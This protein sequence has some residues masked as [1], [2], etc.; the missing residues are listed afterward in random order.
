[1]KKFFITLIAFC[2]FVFLANADV[3]L[4]VAPTTLLAGAKSQVA[5]RVSSDKP[6][7][8]FQ[9]I[10]T[11][12][13]GLLFTETITEDSRT[14][15]GKCD[16]FACD[17]MEDG[18]KLNINCLSANTP[19]PAGDYL[20]AIVP[21]EAS[22]DIALTDFEVS[23][24]NFKAVYDDDTTTGMIE[25]AGSSEISVSD[26]VM[27]DENSD[28]IS[29]VTGTVADVSV[30]RTLKANEWSTIC[31][32][33]DVDA[34]DLAAVFGGEVEVAEFVGNEVNDEGNMIV[35][36]SAPE[37]NFLYGNVPYI[38]KSSVDVETFELEAVEVIPD[39]EAAVVTV[40]TGKN[41][42]FVASGAFIGTLYAGRKIPS[43]VEL[44]NKRS[45]VDGATLFISGGK[46]YYTSE[47]TQPIKAFRGYFAFSE[48]VRD[49]GVKFFV[50]GEATRINEVQ[51]NV[52]KS[53][54]I[55]D[56]SG[57]QVRNINN[58]KGVFIQNG[59]K[60]VK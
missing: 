14:D 29:A 53:G 35:E 32:P 40:G 22:A 31:L 5:L 19:I 24:S 27:L 28:F 58:L 7:Q 44:Q 43:T 9:G 36:F 59:K 1:M 34:A 57:K 8:S 21:V 51:N 39:E 54:A 46:F 12:P 38:I 2:N 33:F 4:Y 41:A 60:V 30:N 17:P 49:A 50:N 18:Q 45:T 52:A 37:D 55:Y 6:V 10:V 48:D 13:A 3:S 15:G 47:A 11:L 56:L 23:V 25:N 26:K 42:N 20:L 16:M